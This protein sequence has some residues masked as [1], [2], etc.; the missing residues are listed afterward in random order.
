MF[1][2]DTVFDQTIAIRRMIVKTL[3]SIPKEQADFIAPTWKNNAR[4]HAGHLIVTPRLLTYGKMGLPLGLPENYRKWFVKGSSPDEWGKDLVPSFG[5]LAESIV[6]CMEELFGSLRP[7]L[8]EAFPKPYTT[9]TGVILKNAAESLNFSLVHD[10]IHLG[11]LMAI[12]RNLAYPSGKPWA[13]RLPLDQ[14]ATTQ[15]WESFR[16]NRDEE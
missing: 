15:H 6:P 11:N 2:I 7:R 9:S 10:G 4:W 1:P 3:R 12:R 8:E 5:D 13:T 16:G 14:E